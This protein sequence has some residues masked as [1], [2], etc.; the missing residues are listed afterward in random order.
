MNNYEYEVCNTQTWLLKEFRFRKGEYRGMAVVIK[1]M[2][3]GARLLGV[4]SQLCH[5]LGFTSLGFHFL[6]CNLEII[7]VKTSEDYFEG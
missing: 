7:I 6:T 3:F 2:D 5:L 4:E 1:S